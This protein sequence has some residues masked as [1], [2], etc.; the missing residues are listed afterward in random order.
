MRK[1]MMPCNNANDRA[2]NK[3][4]RVRYGLRVGLEEEV[5]PHFNSKEQETVEEERRLMSCSDSGKQRVFLSLAKSS[6]IWSNSMNPPSRFLREIP[7]ELLDFQSETGFRG[8][9]FGATGGTHGPRAV[10]VLSPR[11]VAVRRGAS[12]S[13]GGGLDIDRLP[14]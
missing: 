9:R 11:Q 7:E 10:G 4:A 5:F 13:R 14:W 1:M 8:T 12:G 3:R 6:A 2:C